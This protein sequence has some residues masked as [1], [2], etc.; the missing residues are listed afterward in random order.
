[1]EGYRSGKRGISRMA[2]STPPDATE[3][4]N[5]APTESQAAIFQG[6]L[7]SLGREVNQER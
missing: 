3:Q 4:C 7:L 1:M 2:Q 5:E 6:S